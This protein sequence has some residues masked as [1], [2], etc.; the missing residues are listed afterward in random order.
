MLTRHRERMAGTPSLTGAGLLA[1]S[2]SAASVDR[3]VT[4]GP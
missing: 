4:I 2:A 3:A 1:N